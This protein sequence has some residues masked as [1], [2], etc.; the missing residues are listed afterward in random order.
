[1]GRTAHRAKPD[2][3]DLVNVD[4]LPPN[5]RVLCRAIGHRKAFALCKARGGVPLQVPKRPSLTHWLVEIIGF[6]GLQALVDALGDSVID[7]PKYDKVAMQLQ[8]RAVHACLKSGL[9]LTKTAL[10]T[11]YTKRHVLNIQTDLAHA[12]GDLYAHPDAG[13]QR[14]L[15]AE[16]LVAKPLHDDDHDFDA[17]EEAA[18]AEQEAAVNVVDQEH[19]EV[20]LTASCGAHDPFGIGR[21]S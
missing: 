19:R 11:G 3:L 12:E 7:V 17:M 16:L 2:P 10:K 18:V 20:A 21:R 4:L 9:G 13:E 15:F 5:L 14:D 1:M 8:H 6:D